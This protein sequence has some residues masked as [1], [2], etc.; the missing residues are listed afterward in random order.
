MRTRTLTGAALAATLAV[1]LT[2]CAGDLPGAG[3]AE[4]DYPTRAVELVLPFG[5]GGATDIAARAMAEALGQQLGQPLNAT[6]QTGA[7]QVPAVS[8]VLGAAADGY[9]LLADGAGSSSIQSLLPDL[10]YEWDDRTFIANVASG[11]HAYAVGAASGVTTLGELEEKAQADP[12]SFRVAWLGGTTTSDYATLQLLDEIDVDPAD[13]VRV[14]FDGS[15]E[16]MQAAAAGDVDLASGGSSAI[17]SLYSS[18]DLVPLALTAEDPNYPEI[19]LASDEGY[20]E[21]DLQY[22]V[23]LSGPAGLPEPVVQSLVDAL[24]ELAE[25][26]QLDDTFAK[27]GMTVDIVTG[28]ELDAAVHEEAETFRELGELVG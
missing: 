13:V 8:G 23:G 14:P 2:G 16:A 5:S 17:A 22:W 27:L 4:S 3:T 10:P 1:G 12:S 6:N 20:E 26:G 24:G 19:P 25:G 21:L 15:G 18:G 28:D 7:Q 9:T 11:A